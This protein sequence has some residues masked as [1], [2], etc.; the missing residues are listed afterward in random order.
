[1]SSE[2]GSPR[3]LNCG[4][5]LSGPYCSRCGQGDTELRVSLRRLAND[6]LA[7]QLGLESKVPTT[8]WTLIRHPGKLTKDYLAGR[9]V[10]ALLPLRLYLSAS[11]VYFLMLSL[12][13][14]GSSFKF[15]S[16]KA[17][18]AGLDSSGVH[19]STKTSRVAV[20]D[21]TVVFD[22]ALSNGVASRFQKNRLGTL[23]GERLRRFNGMKPS[24]IGA[25]FRERFVHYMPNVIFVLLPV[26]TLILYLMYRKTGRFFAEHLIFT[27]HIHA[28]AFVALIILLLLPDF[29]SWVV[30][31][32]ILVHLYIAMR[33]VYGES[34]WRTFGKFA[35][36]M[37]GYNIVLQ[38]TMLALLAAI[39]ATG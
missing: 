16:T 26:F 21:S 30:P 14:F 33:R 35:A 19:F 20:S 23:A 29:I 13:I 37:I 5:E 24:E 10:R 36:L 31:V 1:M 18:R 6:F 39:F 15:N 17:D 9:R 34:G 27:L 38:L 25:F 3:C 4:A 22:S 12:P 28:F 7:E 8:L 2:A 11:V 32:W